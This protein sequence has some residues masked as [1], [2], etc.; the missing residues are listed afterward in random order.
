V[1]Q[2]LAALVAELLQRGADAQPQR[3]Q[4]VAGCRSRQRSQCRLERRQRRSIAE[5]RQRLRR[6]LPR[7]RRRL[8]ALQ[9]GF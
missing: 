1:Q 6:R 5:R 2:G 4:L 8:C 7:R 3:G 9:H